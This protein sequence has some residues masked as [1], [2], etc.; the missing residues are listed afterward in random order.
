MFLAFIIKNQFK[1]RLPIV[2][3]KALQAINSKKI[4][5]FWDQKIKYTIPMNDI[6]YIT[7][8]TI[9]Q[10]SVIVTSYSVFE[11]NK[12]LIEMEAMLDN[13]FVKSHRSCIV[14][15]KRIIAINK[16]LHVITFDNGDRTGLMNDQL[17]K[18]I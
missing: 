17:K 7:T 10:K 2:I 12:T 15:T 11:I 14:N 4:L 1:K 13:R 5:K 18:I 6:L 9:K 3:E 8:N 16:N